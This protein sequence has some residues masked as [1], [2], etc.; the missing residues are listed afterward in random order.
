MP[1]RDFELP[2]DRPTL[3]AEVLDEITSHTPAAIMR[4]MRR[5]PTGQVSLIH[6]QVLTTLDAGGALP[7]SRLAEALDVSQAS[8]TGIV[9]RMEQRGLVERRGDPD[10]RR[11]V[12][13]APTDEGRGMIEGV[14][15]ERKERLMR[16]LD[17]LTDDELDGFLRGS[18]ALR[19]ARRR[20]H[21]SLDGDEETPNPEPVKTR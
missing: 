2:V 15:A 18:R 16:L 10:D 4:A 20:L 8:A 3:L 13:V 14:S 6:L 17:E 1:L 5:W 9:D 12:L 21:G 7:M 19:A 11:V